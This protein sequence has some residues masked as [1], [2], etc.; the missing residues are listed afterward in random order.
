[1]FATVIIGTASNPSGNKLRFPLIRVKAFP[2]F[3]DLGLKS[4]LEADL[5]RL[6]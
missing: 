3:Q 6:A 2:S 5:E 1:M 4:S